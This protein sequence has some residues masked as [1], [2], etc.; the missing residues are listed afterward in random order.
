MADLFYGTPVRS[1]GNIARHAG[2]WLGGRLG[3]RRQSFPTAEAARRLHAAI[4]P[5]PRLPRR[6]YDCP[7]KV[8]E[9]E[10]MSNRTR[11][12]M[13]L[14]AAA[15]YGLGGCADHD[16]SHDSQAAGGSRDAM[17]PQNAPAAVHNEW[18]AEDKL[19][20]A[21][22]DERK[23]EYSRAM[24]IYER[25][26]SFPPDSRP[27]DLEQRIDSLRQKMQTHGQPGQPSQPGQQGQ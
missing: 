15:L 13:L 24:E 12:A 10:R 23:G 4:H 1:I 7:D 2:G 16:R 22:E 20:E 17:N 6:G 14:L 9:E 11:F 8:T 18:N 21:A 19:K 27:T 25:L 5:F 3:G 26:R